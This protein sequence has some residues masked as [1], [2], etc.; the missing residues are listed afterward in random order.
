MNKN[1][2]RII[3]SKSKRMFIAVAENISSRGKASGQ[4]AVMGHPAEPVSQPSATSLHQCWQVRGLVACMSLLMAL[5]PVYANIQADSAAAAARQPVIAAGTNAQG[6][7]VP[8]VNIQTPQNGISH[9]VYN[10]FDVLQQ[11]VVLNNSRGGAQSVLAG[12]VAA[13]PF[14]QTGEARMILNEVKSSEASRFEG[15]LE[16][17]GQRADVVIASPSGINVQGGGFINV[18]RATLTTGQPHFNED[19]SLQK[20]VVDQGK[21][22]INAAEGSHLGL[23]GNNNTAQYVDIYAKAVELNAETRASQTL[24]IVTGSNTFEGEDQA[25]IT[26]NQPGSTTENF[27]LDVKALGGM[28]A[29]NIYIVGTDK[30]LGVSNAGYT[31]FQNNLVITNAG[32]VENTGQLASNNSAASLISINTDE[33][34]DIVNNGKIAVASG[35]ILLD[36]GQNISLDGGELVKNEAGDASAISVSAQGDI[37]LQNGS[38]IQN[39]VE[40]GDIYLEAGNIQVGNAD[41]TASVSGNGQ[42]LLNARQNLST[43]SVGNLSGKSDVGLYAGNQLSVSNT[44]LRSDTGNLNLVTT[45]ENSAAMLNSVGLNAAGDVNIS[46]TGNVSLNQLRLNRNETGD[47]TLSRNFSVESWGDLSWQNAADSIPTLSGK[48]DLRSQGKLDISGSQF[49]AREGINLQGRELAVNSKLRSDQ[50]ISLTATEQDV[51]LNLGIELS[52]A[53][54]INVAALQGSINTHSLQANS[55][56][57]KISILAK[58]NVELK[59]HQAIDG[60]DSFIKETTPTTISGGN[61]ITIGSLGDGVVGLTS[62]NLKATN[63]DI[64][65]LSNNGINF[66]NNIDGYYGRPPDYNQEEPYIQ[67]NLISS[68]IL[69]ENKNSATNISN[70]LLEAK[71]NVEIFS[72]DDMYLNGMNLKSGYHTAINSNGNISSGV[73]STIDS[74]GLLSLV[75]KKSINAAFLL[76]GGSVLVEADNIDASKISAKTIDSD[77]LKNNLDL[78]ELNGD[79]TIQANQELIFNKKKIYSAGDLNLISKNGALTIIGFDD[80]PYAKGIIDLS[81]FHADGNILFEGNSVQLSGAKINAKNDINIISTQNDFRLDGASLAYDDTTYF[82]ADKRNM[83]NGDQEKTD[84]LSSWVMGGVEN[85]NTQLISLEGD[86]NLASKKGLSITGADIDAKQ[87]YVN[88]QAQGALDGFYKTTAI[89][90]DNT[91]K[92]M[93]ASIIIDGNIDAYGKGRES[94]QD[95]SYREY[96][97]PT[98]INGEAGVNIRAM[99]ESINDNIILQGVGITSNK[100]DVNIEANKSILFDVALETL[101]DRST[102]IETKRSWYGKKKV[103]TTTAIGDVVDP[104]SVDIYGKNINVVSAFKNSIRSDGTRDPNLDTSIDIYSARFNADGG[105]VSIQSGGNLNFLTVSAINNSN[106]NTV[107]KSSWLGLNLG[108]SKTNATRNQTTQLPAQL[109]ADYIE[110]KSGYDTRLDGTEFEY[111]KT[112]KIQA[113]GTITLNAIMD[114]VEETLQ[115]EKTSTI[116]QSMQD[117]GSITETGKLPSFNGPTPPVFHAEGGLEVQIPIGER[118]QNRVELMDEVLKLARQPGNEYLSGL[119]DRNDVDWQKTILTQQDWDYK[120]QGLTGAGAA[121]I[122]IIVT[123]VT[124]GTGTAAATSVAGATG[125]TALGAGAQAAVTTLASQASVSLINN[126]GDIGKTLK[127]LGSKDNV[128]GLVASVVTAGLLNQVGTTLG[129]QPDS[130]LL[131][132]RIINNF[133][134]SVG[135]T[136][137]QTAVNGGSLQDNLEAAFLSGLVGVVQGQLAFEVKPLENIDY[138]LHKIAHAAVGCLAGSIQKQCEAGA[139]GASIGEIVASYFN[140]GTRQLS[141]NEKE[142]IIGKSKIVAATIAAYTGHDVNTAANAA[143]IAV[144]NNNMEVIY[145]AEVDSLWEDSK[146]NKDAYYEGLQKIAERDALALDILMLPLGGG[147]YTFKSFLKTAEILVSKANIVV[148]KDGLTAAARKLSSHAQRTGGTF[149]KPTGNIAQQ[150]AQAEE[151]LR[152]ILNNPQTRVTNLTRGGIEY[153]MPNGQGV[154]YNADGSFSSFLDPKRR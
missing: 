151:I 102:K 120:Q 19:G 69:I 54:D 10:Q 95:Y 141:E 30:G 148:T 48:L 130:T 58:N 87:G 61:G 140:D 118:D 15:N 22:S 36:S 150:N 128:K 72:N 105:Q 6:Q 93:G 106:V 21:V 138:V 100:G 52:S 136:L 86:I 60:T 71:G 46:G 124:M 32:K 31:H 149:P 152:N 133:T 82:F 1:R 59:S 33:G 75:G 143:D 57:G 79:L 63:G 44:D 53:A 43:E 39:L 16:V 135:S 74:S 89:E 99:G 9:N 147:L 13:N 154:R 116:W 4:T 94:D 123:I 40:G 42:V 17:A 139:I 50:G 5:T 137:V 47:A 78:S 49:S 97:N 70:T 12:Q 88:I 122:V 68:N 111:L 14:L 103:I 76:T 24:K 18:N 142:Q 110:T 51:N 67:N 92:T 25:Q 28:Y 114:R 146:G 119:V 81:E 20:F 83:V 144:R 8:V 125:S 29:N 91:P 85:F 45:D 7:Q 11:G 56:E 107:K 108:T 98:D 23:G 117:K 145:Q 84:F 109:K 55:S 64:Y 3:F 73:F 66:Y 34:A 80:S 101:Y 134:N 112:A 96:V 121:L 26:A 129:L 153:R 115:R 35:S 132:D 104:A 38:N 62:V 2:Y 41:S 126:G 77:I 90:N 65:I 37:S 27:A 113:G 127:D 131:S